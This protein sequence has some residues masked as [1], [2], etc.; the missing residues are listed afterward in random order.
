MD[1][2]ENLLAFPAC[3]NLDGTLER[4]TAIAATLINAEKVSIVLWKAASSA[5]AENLARDDL[6]LKLLPVDSSLRALPVQIDGLTIGEM[7]IDRPKHFALEDSRLLA[8][9]ALLIGKSIQAAQ[10][11]AVLRSRF[12]QLSLA[13]AAGKT[14]GSALAV[15]SQNPNQVARILAKSFYREL[16][17][18]GFSVKQIINAATEIISQVSASLKKHKDRHFRNA[19]SGYTNAN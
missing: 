10:L 1:H 14:L 8:T 12:V 16:A 4:L 5:P 18:A 9:L 11:Q 17:S 19:S 3:S 7:V 13:Q 2:S 6:G 15:C